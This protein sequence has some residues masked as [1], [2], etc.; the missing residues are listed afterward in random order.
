MSR[1]SRAQEFYEYG[2]RRVK[3][4]PPPE[5]QKFLPGEFVN[6]KK[7]LNASMSHFEAGIPAMIEY[8]HAHAFHGDDIDSYSLLIRSNVEKKW[9][10]VAWYDEGQLTKIEDKNTIE[11]YK[12]EIENGRI[13]E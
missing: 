6:I 9:K 8:T 3:E 4:T 10:S 13:E 7:V 1:F 12:K 5:M 2:M 11:K